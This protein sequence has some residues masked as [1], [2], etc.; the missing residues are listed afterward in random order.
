MTVKVDSE[1]CGNVAE[2]TGSGLCIKLCEQGAMVDDNGS[3]KVI[4]ENC[5]DCNICIQSCP[6]QAISKA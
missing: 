2:C 1:K 6:N 5:D 3:L 4:D